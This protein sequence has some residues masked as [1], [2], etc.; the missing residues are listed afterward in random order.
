MDT[1][2]GVFHGVDVCNDYRRW[3][4]LGGG[5]DCN[6]LVGVSFDALS[7]FE[8]WLKASLFGY[9]VDTLTT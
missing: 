7:G 2:R 5:C 1:T 4:R 8:I 6:F 9:V 3:R